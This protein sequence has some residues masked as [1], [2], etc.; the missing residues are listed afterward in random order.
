MNFR[1]G[2]IEQPFDSPQLPNL[3]QI[4]RFAF[5]QY[6][7]QT[8][9]D[10]YSATIAIDEIMIRNSALTEF[11]APSQPRELIENFESYPGE[12]ELLGSYSYLNSPA[13]TLTVASIESPAPEGN[14]ALKLAID[15][16]PGQYPWGSIRS[17]K[18]NP[19]SFPENGVLSFQFK[20][21]PSLAGVADAGTSFWISF[22]DQAGRGI[23]YVVPASVVTNSEW[24][25]LEA[26]LADFGDTSAVDIGNLVQWRILAQGWEGTADSAAQSAA[27][28][29]DDIKI[30][31]PPARPSLGIR[32]DAT[33]VVISWPAAITGYTLESTDK[34]S[35]GT[36][37]AVGGVQGSEATVTPAAGNRFFR[38]RK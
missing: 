22:Y 11:P 19:F 17:T 7:S 6:G 2:N 9:I 16:A 23:N 1:V 27:V 5:F 31:I 25:S 4:V 28:Y 24:T 38:L 35:G 26:T 33:G 8:A 37:V 12:T 36:W 14:K 15:F 3:N 10:P 21:D 20:G 30:T 18:V 29:V 34:V 13:A 32:R